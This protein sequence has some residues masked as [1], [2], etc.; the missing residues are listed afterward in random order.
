MQFNTKAT[1]KITYKEHKEIV[2]LV[3]FDKPLCA[4]C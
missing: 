1:K 3:F 2:F 4:L